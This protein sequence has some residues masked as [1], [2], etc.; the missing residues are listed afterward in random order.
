MPGSNPR[1]NEMEFQAAAD[2]AEENVAMIGHCE[3]TP[4][5]ETHHAGQ[6]RTALTEEEDPRSTT[7]SCSSTKCVR[8]PSSRLQ[9][10]RNPP[11]PLDLD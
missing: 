9:H 1:D 7:G 2:D 10:A 4:R 8:P 5:N 6:I 3:S 11:L